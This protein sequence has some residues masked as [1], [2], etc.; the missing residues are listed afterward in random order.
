MSWAREGQFPVSFKQR[1]VILNH[2]T[3]GHLIFQGHLSPGFTFSSMLGS[4]A[5]LSFLQRFCQKLPVMLSLAAC[6]FLHSEWLQC[7]PQAFSSGVGV[8]T[9]PQTRSNMSTKQLVMG[10]G[11]FDAA[12]V[13]PLPDG[14]SQDGSARLFFVAIAK[15]VVA[16]HITLHHYTLGKIPAKIMFLRHVEV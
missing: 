10:S 6:H 11:C 1:P 12:L 15:A 16:H 3:A 14:R 4:T 7:V 13:R 9:R 2:S 5:F 8:P